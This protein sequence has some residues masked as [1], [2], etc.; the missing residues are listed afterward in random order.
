MSLIQDEHLFD[1][2]LPRYL[3]S[4]D[5]TVPPFPQRRWL[6]W[7]M[8]GVY[9]LPLLFFVVRYA[10]TAPEPWVGTANAELLERVAA[11]VG[12]TDFVQLLTTFSPP[13]GVLPALVLPSE[14][15]LAIAGALV[16][17]VFLQGLDQ[18]MFRRGLH[19]F[20]RLVMLVSLMISPVFVL[21]ALT[22][23]TLFGAIVLFGFGLIDLVRFENLANTQA[24]FRAGLLFAGAALMDVRAVPLVLTVAIVG[25]LLIH[26]RPQAR[27]ANAVI[28]AF[29]TAAV[30]VALALAGIIIGSGP[31]TFLRTDAASAMAAIDTLVSQPLGQPLLLYMAPVI[32]VGLTAGVFGFPRSGLMMGLIALGALAGVVVGAPLIGAAAVAYLLVHISVAVLPAE[33]TAQHAA[34]VVM[35]AVLVGLVGWLVAAQLPEADQWSVILTGVNPSPTPTG[36]V[37]PSPTGTG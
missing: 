16:S 15:L 20:I 30:T 36:T 6:R 12:V 1:R 21:L 28:V 24:G 34:I 32:V 31:F 27:S 23:I 10:L 18:A 17:G 29:P 8:R 35:C 4:L 22:D 7:T 19:P 33:S 37:I 11:G 3:E 9:A 5:G 26:S 2:D 14:L 13:L 25:A